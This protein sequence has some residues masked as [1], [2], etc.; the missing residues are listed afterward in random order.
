MPD[1][2][3]AEECVDP[4]DDLR[5]AMADLRGGGRDDL[6]MERAVDALAL[7]EAQLDGQG[8]ARQ[9]LAYHGGPAE[10]HLGLG[11]AAPAEHRGGDFGNRARNRFHGHDFMPSL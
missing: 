10:Y 7:A 4:L 8:I 6:E 2:P 5:L 9:I 3:I 11:E 1:R